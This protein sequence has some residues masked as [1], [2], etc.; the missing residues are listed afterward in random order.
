MKTNAVRLIEQ[1]GI[2]YE[3]REYECSEDDLDA[4]SVARKIGM[5]PESVFKTL[6][7]R[8]ERT[9]VI[10]ACIPA[11]AELDLK[12]IASV[13]GNKKVELVAVREIQSL[14]GY[15]RGGVSPL[16]T[17]KR[18]QLFLDR[19]ALQSSTISVS[20]GKR[21][22]QILL[23]TGDLVNASQAELADPDTLAL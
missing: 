10:M 19:S 12:K 11:N 22:L 15:I 14:T 3:L 4:V 9:G 8:G 5:A 21:G 13:S 1:Q 6:V 20:A 18:F 16:G 17:K 2:R 7:A 23:S